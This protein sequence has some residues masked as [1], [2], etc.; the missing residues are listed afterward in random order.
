MPEV[1]GDAGLMV[2]PENEEELGAA[3]LRLAS[4]AG[5]REDLAR[6]GLLRAREYSWE[7]AIESTWSVYRELI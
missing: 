6:R 7:R 5:L 4:D 3:L 1:C 2:D